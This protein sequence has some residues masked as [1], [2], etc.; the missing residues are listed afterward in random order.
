MAKF[1]TKTFNDVTPIVLPDTAKP[2]WVAVPIEFKATAYAQND[3]IELCKLPIGYQCLDWA[4][5]FPD[6]DSGGSPALASSLGTINTAGDD[7]SSE[8]WGSGLTAGQ[9]TSIVRNT[10]SAA[11]QGDTTKERTV[12]LKITTVAATYAGSGKVGHLLMLVQA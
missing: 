3:L 9:S 5:V 1:Q 6:I 7:I 2:E 11:A 4:L 10:T 8:V 12:V